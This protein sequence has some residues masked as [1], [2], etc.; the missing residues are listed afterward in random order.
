[1]FI[2]LIVPDRPSRIKALFAGS[3]SVIVSWRPPRKTHGKITHYTVHWASP[4][5]KKHSR[6]RIIDPHTTH[7][8]INDLDPSTYQV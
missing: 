7:A 6:T 2:L 1:M 5:E 4:G 3:R 8:M